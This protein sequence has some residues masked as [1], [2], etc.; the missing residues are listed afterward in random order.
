MNK[1]QSNQVVDLESELLNDE[2]L[3]FFEEKILEMKKTAEIKLLS[4]KSPLELEEPSSEEEVALNASLDYSSKVVR[5]KVIKNA[6]ETIKKCGDAI[7]R[8]QNKSFGICHITKRPI[9][10]EMLM[11]NFFMTRLPGL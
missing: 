1:E 7:S 4:A 2:N 6:E 5:E 10:K 8:I 3:A 11:K 9:P